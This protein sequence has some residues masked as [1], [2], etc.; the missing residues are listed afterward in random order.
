MR[1]LL[2]VRVVPPAPYLLLAH[3]INRSNLLLT[4]HVF[5]LPRRGTLQGKRFIL[6][7][8]PSV[9]DLKE[10]L[11]KI[12]STIFVEYVIKNPL[13]KIR[14]VS[15][16]SFFAGTSRQ[17]R[18]RLTSLSLSLSHTHTHPA[19]C[20]SLLAAEP[21]WV[22]DSSPHASVR[23]RNAETSAF[24]ESLKECELFTSEL[25][26]YLQSLPCWSSA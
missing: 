11:R 21:R 6:V 8:D 19:A 15:V 25:H 26:K 5:A 13:F 7:T 1:H 18:T 4:L 9:G 16:H 10:E 17:R 20:C 23:C 12:Y 22:P 14:Y 3:T 2:N 24:E